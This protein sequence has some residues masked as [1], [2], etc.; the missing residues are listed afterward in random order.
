MLNSTLRSVPCLDLQ[1]QFKSQGNRLIP[2][3][4][5]EQALMYQRMFEGLAFYEKLSKTVT[6]KSPQQTGET[7]CS[8]WD[9]QAAI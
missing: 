9:L 6:L 3:S 2:D 4:P 5:A 8:V 1:S 7:P